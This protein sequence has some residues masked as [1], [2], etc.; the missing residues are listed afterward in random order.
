MTTKDHSA[1]NPYRIG[2]QVQLVP[3]SGAYQ[4]PIVGE[5]VSVTATQV[6]VKR[7]DKMCVIKHRISDGKP[8]LKYDQQFPCYR[9]KP[10]PEEEQAQ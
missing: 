6:G 10:M 1:T 5:V 7:P 9:V 4:P 2:Q 8:V 3:E